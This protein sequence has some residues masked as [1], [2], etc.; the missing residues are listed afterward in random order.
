[1]T[2]SEKC[3]AIKN[4]LIYFKSIH[5]GVY[6]VVGEDKMVGA[7]LLCPTQIRGSKNPARIERIIFFFFIK[8]SCKSE[9]S[10][11]FKQFFAIWPNCSL[12]RKY[13]LSPLLMS[14]QLFTCTHIR[15]SETIGAVWFKNV[16]N[17]IVYTRLSLMW[18]LEIL[19]SLKILFRRGWLRW[20]VWVAQLFSSRSAWKVH[21]FLSSLKTY[22]S[23][24]IENVRLRK[25]LF[26]SEFII[27]R[28]WI[29]FQ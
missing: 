8:I 17:E 10:P 5:D 14:N 29:I 12:Y 7:V 16:F 27:N 21:C 13:I 23:K 11:H 19:E 1:M 4:I 2:S 28:S 22:F 6:N 3:D 25:T 26:D 24:K 9:E 15:K 20:R 18:N